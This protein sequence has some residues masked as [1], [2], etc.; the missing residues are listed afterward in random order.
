M[1][2]RSGRYRNLGVGVILSAVD[3]APIPY[4]APE[5]LKGVR[6]TKHMMYFGDIAEMKVYDMPLMIT[7]KFKKRIEVGDGYYI[8][9]NECIKLKTPLSN[10]ANL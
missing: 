5:I 9:D 1:L 6:D 8:K 2:F 7:R 3:N 10:E 4:N